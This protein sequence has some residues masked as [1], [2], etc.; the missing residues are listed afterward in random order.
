[1]SNNN[2]FLPYKLT[3]NAFLLAFELF[4]SMKYIVIFG[5]ISK[6]VEHLV[7][8]YLVCFIFVYW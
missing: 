6:T 8:W 5:K 7:F 3:D 1:M 4:V 2:C